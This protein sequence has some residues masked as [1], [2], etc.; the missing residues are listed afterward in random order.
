MKLRRCLASH[1]LLFLIVCYLSAA[2][3][4]KSQESIT[5][6]D[7]KTQQAKIVGSNGSTVQ[8][9]VGAGMV[10]VP[11]SSISQVTMAPPADY[12]AAVAAYESKDFAKALTSATLVTGKYKGLPTE[13]AQQA[14]LMLGDIYVAQNDLARA[15][16]AYMDFQKLYPGQG[17]T[18]ADV[19][20][21]R[22]AISK[23][24]Y[25][26]AKQ[27]LEPLAAQALKEKNIPRNAASSYS[28]V[29]YLLGQTREAEGDYPGA[30]Q[31]YLRTVT[32]FY[33]DH[34][35]VSGAQ[36]RAD[37]LRKAHPGLVAP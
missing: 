23:K 15:E 36:E 37:A 5:T 21:A 4:L 6:R 22:I 18:Q 3:S 19:C 27:K 1:Q 14:A 25:A 28:Q 12:A 24:D 7:G 31:D 16:T 2:A 33:Q 8:L 11:L 13:W 26:G 17:S 35:A 10:G 20:M 9:Q 29:F 30:L 34:P 32:L